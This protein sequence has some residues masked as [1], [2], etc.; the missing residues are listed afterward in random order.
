LSGSVLERA[1]VWEETPWGAS[2][3]QQAATSVAARFLSMVVLY[4][5]PNTKNKARRSSG[6]WK[7]FYPDETNGL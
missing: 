3:K 7:R 6:L 4:M 5:A 2:E 1:G